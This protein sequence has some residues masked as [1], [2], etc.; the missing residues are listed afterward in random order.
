MPPESSNKEPPL[1]GSEIVAS[2][3]ARNKWHPS[4]YHSFGLSERF[5]ILL[6]SPMTMNLRRAML[7]KVTRTPV[8]DVFDWDPMGRTV[9]HLVDKT[10]GKKH[11]VSYEAR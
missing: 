9:I 7:S 10:T 3:P 4:Y 6:E 8:V 11:E 2:I 1:K 5:V